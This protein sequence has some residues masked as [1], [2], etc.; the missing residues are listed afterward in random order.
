MSDKLKIIFAGTPEIAKL[1][2][3]KI[4]DTGFTV[5]LVLTQPDRPAGRGMKLTSSPVKDLAMQLG[6]EVFQPVSF[7]NN[8]LAIEK[9]KA[10]QPDII[11]VVAYG[12]ILP[13]IILDIPRLGCVNIHVSLL[14]KHRGAA[15][16]QR[17][18]L[19]GDSVTGV[20]IMQMDAGL[21]TGDMLMCEEEIIDTGET[22]GSLHDKLAIRGANMI[23]KYLTNYAKISPVKQVN[24]GA[25]YANKISKAEAQINWSESAGII[26]RKIRG[27]NPYPGAYTFANDDKLVKIWQ[28]RV[29]SYVTDVESG[30]VIDYNNDCIAVSCGGGSVLEI[31]ELQIAGEKRKSAKQVISNKGVCLCL[32]II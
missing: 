16:I 11:V 18:L 15:P 13:Q 10:I 5:D 19:V 3:A 20:T 25:T 17:A 8:I 29:A 26:E 6:I 23:V 2:F 32:E 24:D 4:I 22:S 12:L 28:A 30:K 27:Y 31:L 9:I 14:P 7:K 1:C 21:D